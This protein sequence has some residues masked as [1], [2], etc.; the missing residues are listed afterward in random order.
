MNRSFGLRGL[1]VNDY[2]FTVNKGTKNE[3]AIKLSDLLTY[4][5]HE[6]NFSYLIKDQGITLTTR[7][8]PK[9]AMQRRALY[10]YLTLISFIDFLGISNSVNNNFIQIEGKARFLLKLSTVGNTETF[11]NL[12][13][14]PMFETYLNASFV[15]GNNVG[16]RKGNVFANESADTLFYDHFDLLRNYNIKSGLTLGLFSLQYK[17]IHSRIYGAMDLKMFRTSFS[18]TKV[19]S[20]LDSLVQSN[21]FSLSYSPS[22]IL[23]YRPDFNIGADLRLSMDIN[24]SPLSF[25]SNELRFLPSKG[26]IYND[27]QKFVPLR[28]S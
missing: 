6:N 18:F 10:N 11:S 4:T 8:A 7:T 13:L 20:G 17:S 26:P 19:N 9:V 2:F 14:F 22:V 25:S 28:K 16:G 5:K 15:N 23:E 24:M 12:T 1:N 3:Y 21:V 27:S